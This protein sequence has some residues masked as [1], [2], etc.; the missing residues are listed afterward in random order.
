MPSKEEKPAT[1]TTIKIEKIPSQKEKIEE[2]PKLVSKPIEKP[3]PS[4]TKPLEEKPKLEKIEKKPVVVAKDSK[5]I[6]KQPTTKEIPAPS[7]LKKTLTTTTVPVEKKPIEKKPIPTKKTTPGPSTATTIGGITKKTNFAKKIDKKP[8]EEETKSL[9][10]KEEATEEVEEENT[11]QIK[12]EDDE[13]S[14]NFNPESTQIE[15]EDGSRFDGIEELKL[16]RNEIDEKNYE[17]S[18]KDQEIKEL[19]I[20]LLEVTKRYQEMEK[21]KEKAGNAADFEN[22][23][24]LKVMQVEQKLKEAE[25]KSKHMEN[26]YLRLKKEFELQKY[27]FIYILLCLTIIFEFFLIG[28]IKSK[29]F[30]SINKIILFLFKILKKEIICNNM[31]VS[32]VWSKA[33]R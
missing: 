12:V 20:R 10:S 19:N 6:K 21:D 22:L 29:L 27:F 8:L 15:T 11:E 1:E 31:K 13:C 24:N 7:T 17:I 3:I 25:R 14:S 16:L 28:D 30:K 32:L 33:C 9:D 4:T 2:K 23:N 18:T 26:D 5:L